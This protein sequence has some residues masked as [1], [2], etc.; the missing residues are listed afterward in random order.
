MKEIINQILKE[1]ETARGIIEKA[2]EDAQNLIQ[3]TQ[4]DSKNLLDKT[5][6][7][8]KNMASQKQKEAENKFFTER[9]K[10][11]M[12][13]KSSSVIMREAK[14]KDINPIAREFFLKI[15]DIKL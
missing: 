12:E 15:I 4:K 8:I 11:L 13:T 1:E 7:D 2:R 14:E 6:V 10:T 3:K 5:L 9:E